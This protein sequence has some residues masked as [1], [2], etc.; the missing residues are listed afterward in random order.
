MS[1][2]RP[3]SVPSL[4]RASAAL[5]DPTSHD[6]DIRGHFGVFGG[7]YVPEALMAVMT[8]AGPAA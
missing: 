2:I 7:R 3:A 6:A 8:A 5:A 1:D 4:P